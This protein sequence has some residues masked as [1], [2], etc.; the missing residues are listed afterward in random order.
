MRWSEIEKNCPDS[1]NK[2]VERM[3]PNL[4]VI[5]VYVL[6]YFDIKRLYKFFDENGLYLIVEMYNPKQWQCSIS[7]DNGIVVTP[8]TE[9]KPCREEIE[10]EGFTECF[11]LLD[12]MLKDK[13]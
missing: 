6:E 2:F 11:K 4:G 5:S 13:K 7:F 1:Y 8:K 9:S 12:K 10:E 3:F